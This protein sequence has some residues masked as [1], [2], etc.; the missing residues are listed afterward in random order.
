MIIWPFQ[1]QGFVMSVLTAV[2]VLATIVIVVYNRKYGYLS[3]KK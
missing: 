3:I 1:N 2:Y